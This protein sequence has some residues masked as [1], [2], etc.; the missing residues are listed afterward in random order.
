MSKTKAAALYE[1]FN[2]FLTFYPN[3]SV[4]E[5]AKYPYGTY[6]FIASAWDG[7]EVGLTV[8]LWYY[9]ESES[10]PNAKVQEISDK[11]GRGGVVVP[12]DGGY[13]RLL[14]GSPFSQGVTESD[15]PNVK[16]RYMNITAVYYTE[17]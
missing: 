9:T 16:R 2:Q 11:I 7:G 10:L 15:N 1:F 13:I 17:N 12:C 6:E 5:D 3:T 8:N 14:R 4:P